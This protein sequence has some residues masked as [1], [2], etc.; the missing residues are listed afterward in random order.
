[1]SQ[2]VI[3]AAK[4]TPIGSFGGALSSVAAPKLGG[5]AIKAALNEA[6][7][8]PDQVEEVIMGN[9]LTSGEGQ[10]PARQALLA[11]D[12]QENTAALTIGKVCGSGLKAV[13][14]A[15]QIIRCGDASVIVAGGMENMSAV[16][17]SLDKARNGYRLGNGKL[18]DL[19]I[20]D[21]LW[22]AY[23][24]CHMG[25]MADTCA[26]KHNISRENQDQFAIESYR[27]ANEAVN[28]GKFKAEIATVEVAQ[29]QGDALKI[30]TDEEPGRGKP[31][32]LSYLKPA[33]GKEGSVTAGNASSINDGAAALVLM[34]ESKANELNAKPLVRI[35]AQAQISQDPAWFTT[36]P[37][38]AM[39][40]VLDKANL[41][42]QDIDLWEV[43]EAFAVVSIYNNNKL[44]IPAEKVNVNG[45]AVALGHPI[46]ASGARILVTLI[47]ELLKQ[48]KAKYGLASLCIGGGEAVAVIIEKV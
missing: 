13:M 38:V 36:A 43:N 37:A 27:R 33:F 9:V 10:S 3:V 26:T 21:G 24:N 12:L 2:T 17:Y 40:K 19:M 39:Q 34:S 6:S 23:N 35:I 30:D 11:A 28:A 32:K 31:E 18:E 8:A 15:D 4:R 5:V 22:D 42:P 41:T 1:M 44:E 29:R 20:K 46:G 7:V 25:T 16:P 14:L 47:H 48:D 45:G